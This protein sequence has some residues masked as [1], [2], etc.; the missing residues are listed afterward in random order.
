MN[1]A[2]VELTLSRLREFMREPEAIF[3]AFIFPILMSI[4]MAVAFPSRGATP[5]VIAIEAGDGADA[6]RR[7][8][9]SVP[10]IEIR[11]LASAEQA[12]ALRD[13]DVHLIVVPTDPPTYRFDPAREDG[14]AARL[15]VDDALQ[16]AAGRANVFTA[17]DEPLTIAGSRY[18]DWLIPGLIGLGIMSTGMWGLGFSIVQARMRK[19]LKLLVASPMRK[20]EYLM[21]QL[22]ARLAFLAPEVAIPL[23]FGAIALGMPIVGSIAAIVVVSLVGA[24]AFSALGLLAAS[25]ARTFEAISGMMNLLMTP[26]WILSGVFFAASNFP[27]AL[28]PF[29]QALPLTAL[30]DALRDVILEGATLVEVSGELGVLAAWIA[31][32]FALALRLFKWR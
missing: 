31:G 26:M 24:L 3:W 5:V 27:D 18:I 2:L 17:R 29:I 23:G 19:V 7:A 14:R 32:P 11:N 16:R 8:L 30:V 12:D 1:R 20:H 21:A 28:Q 9:T 6:A 15:V 25:R 10:G 22:F 13:G 4:A